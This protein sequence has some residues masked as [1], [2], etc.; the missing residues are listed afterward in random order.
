[1]IKDTGQSRDPGLNGLEHPTLKHDVLFGSHGDTG[2]RE[3]TRD[4][5]QEKMHI[6]SLYTAPH[7]VGL[8]VWKCVCEREIDMSE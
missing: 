5:W 7:Q 6:A 3:T 1:M 2:A 8:N 4:Q